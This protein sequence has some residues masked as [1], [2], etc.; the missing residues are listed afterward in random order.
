MALQ[1]PSLGAV[2]QRVLAIQ[3]K[4]CAKKPLDFL[5][6]AESDAL[7]GAPDRTTWSDSRDRTLL[8]VAMQTG[9][10]VSELIGLRCQAVVLGTG[11]HERCT[12]KGR[13]TRCVP[14]RKEVVS[15]FRY[16]LRERK[17]QPLSRDGVWVE[18]ASM[19]LA[20]WGLP[21]GGGQL[22][23]RLAAAAAAVGLEPGFSN[24]AS[25]KVPNIRS[26]GS[27]ASP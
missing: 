11:A 19:D 13:K 23:E 3:S 21:S 8:L 26:R 5:T 17:G 16:W 12:G 20:G 15:A 2:A 25:R 10:R 7:V 22:R 9:L 1:E 6:R 24:R 27:V 4:R 14:L 18:T